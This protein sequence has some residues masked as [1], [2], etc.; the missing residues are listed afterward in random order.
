LSLLPDRLRRGPLRRIDCSSRG[1]AQ[2]RCPA[3][4]ATCTSAT[5]IKA[6][7]RSRRSRSTGW[8]VALLCASLGFVSSWPGPATAQPATAPPVDCAKAEAHWKSAQ[9]IDTIEVF[10]DHLARFPN[11]AFATLARLKIEQLKAATPP[12]KSQKIA[13]L[14][15]G[16]H[17]TNLTQ[18]QRARYGIAES[19]KGV[20][21]DGIEP[22]LAAAREGL[23]AGDVITAIGSGGAIMRWKTR[24][25]LDRDFDDRVA[26]Y[27]LFLMTQGVGLELAVARPDGSARLPALVTK[28]V[29]PL[30]DQ[31]IT[32][33]QKLITYQGTPLNDAQADHAILTMYRK[34]IIGVQRIGDARPTRLRLWPG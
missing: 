31:R 14:D 15:Y 4:S 32:Q 19:V 2:S 3:T 26:L 17:L 10:E 23:K 6:P 20:L 30:R 25:E 28:I 13:L 22:G 7:A 21:I 5:N 33:N 18:D 29:Q 16:L 8:A 11:C 24:D 27:G 34:D 12:A 9:E 1:L